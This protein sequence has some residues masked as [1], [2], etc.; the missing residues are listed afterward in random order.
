MSA[1]ALVLDRLRRQQDK[2]REMIALTASSKDVDSLLAVIERKRSILAEVDALE[3]E[4]APLKAD[5]AAIRAAF[6]PDETRAVRET[7]DATQQVLRE[8][9]KVEDEGR[10]HLENRQ[11]LDSLMKQSRARGAYGAK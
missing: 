7:L 1:A 10:A 11:A 8:L 6:T 9:V 2:Y 4:L 3:A 5:W